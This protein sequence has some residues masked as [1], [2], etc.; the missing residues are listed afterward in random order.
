[1]INVQVES[2]IKFLGEDEIFVITRTAEGR[3]AVENN[4]TNENAIGEGVTFGSLERMLWRLRIAEVDGVIVNFGVPIIDRNSNKE[5]HAVS[6]RDWSCK[7][8]E[9]AVKFTENS[10]N[11]FWSVDYEEINKKGA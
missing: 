10:L 1:M 8:F 9:E 6:K 2:R 3:F 4:E 11:E 7:T 5:I